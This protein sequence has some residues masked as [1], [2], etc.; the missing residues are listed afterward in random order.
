L[1]VLFGLLAGCSDLQAVGTP[2][3]DGSDSEAVTD[4]GG[5]ETEDSNADDDPENNTD[6]PRDSDTPDD[7][8]ADPPDEAPDTDNTQVVEEVPD[9][10]EEVPDN[11]EGSD[12]GTSAGLGDKATLNLVNP[13]SSEYEVCFLYVTQDPS[14]DTWSDDLLGTRTLDPGYYVSVSGFDAAWTAVYAEG[15]RDG[16]YWYGDGDLRVGVNTWILGEPLFYDVG[17]DDTGDT[18]GTDTSSWDSGYDSGWSDT[19]YD[20]GWYDTGYDTGGWDTGYDTGWYD[21]GYDTGWYDTG[22]YDTGGY[23][24][25]GYDTGWP[26]TGW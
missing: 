19:G 2:S 14:Y 26:D 21:T 20:T 11:G 25:V 24:T 23:D 7:P 22:W 3:G 8:V 9:D 4:T 18:G 12:T 13:A 5:R 6:T 10:V 17:T 1:S 15:C 16:A